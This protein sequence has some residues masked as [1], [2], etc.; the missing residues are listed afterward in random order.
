MNAPKT[1]HELD[2]V[3]DPDALLTPAAA[4]KLTGFAPVTLRRWERLGQFPAAVVINAKT[5]RYRARD[6]RAWIRAKSE[7]GPAGP[8]E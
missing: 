8:S 3:S 6:V 5:R 1:A 4:G 7:E 2:T